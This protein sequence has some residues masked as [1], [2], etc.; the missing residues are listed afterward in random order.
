PDLTKRAP[1]W[2]AQGIHQTEKSLNTSCFLDERVDGSDKVVL[3]DDDS[4]E[5]RDALITLAYDGNVTWIPQGIYMS[6]CDVDVRTFPFDKQNCSLKFGSWTYDGSK[7]NLDFLYDKREMLTTDYFVANKAW[8]VLETPG[9]RNIISYACCPNVKYHDLTYTVIFRR[10]YYCLNMVL[11]TASTFLNVLVVN[12]SF[13]G[14]R[15]AVMFRYFARAM[16]MNSLV[17][18]FLDADKKRLIPV[19]IPGMG[20]ANGDSKFPRYWKGSCEKLSRQKDQIELDPQ[21]TEIDSKLSEIR[22]FLNVYQERLDYRDKTEKISKEWKALGLIFDR[23]F[24]WIYLVTI[25]TSLSVVLSI[26]FSEA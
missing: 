15:S 14:A 11:I 12:L 19:A 13:Y 7:L 22:E 1:G 20:L 21:L 26:I 8:T 16:C 18:P 6:T 5:R 17:Q 2:S 4:N 24:F 25:L 23:L 9:K 3:A 10:T